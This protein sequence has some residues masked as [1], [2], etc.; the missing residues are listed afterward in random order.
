VLESDDDEQVVSQQI[1]HLKHEENDDNQVVSQ[2]SESTDD[3][4]EKYED[5]FSTASYMAQLNNFIVEKRASY[6]SSSFTIFESAKT[7]GD[8]RLIKNPERIA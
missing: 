3:R 7:I 5:I 4:H 6:R 8:L 2:S 1:K